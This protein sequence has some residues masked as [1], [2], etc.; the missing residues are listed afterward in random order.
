MIINQRVQLHAAQLPTLPEKF[1]CQ[2]VFVR[3]TV[4]SLV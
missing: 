1:F 4:A 2:E 3:L